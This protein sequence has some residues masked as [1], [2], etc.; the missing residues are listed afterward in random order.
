MK[1]TA[2]FSTLLATFA[3]ISCNEDDNTPNPV[4]E[5]ELIT[6]VRLLFNNGGTDQVFE[7]QDLDGDGA[8]PPMKDTIFLV[9]SAIYLLDVEFLNETENP[10]EDVTA[11]IL[12]EDEEHQVFFQTSAGL[13]LSIDYNDSDGD[14]NPLGVENQAETDAP[15]TGTLTVILRHEP[16][17]D[18]SG[19]AD[20]DLTNA[21]GETDVEVVFEVVI[22]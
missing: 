12:A 11:E 17:K 7:W 1:K 6:T 5:E 10:A 13:Q 18:A 14:G 20:G 3:L 2:F 4:N 9:D 16:D 8:N 21:G 15:S 22:Q 19:V